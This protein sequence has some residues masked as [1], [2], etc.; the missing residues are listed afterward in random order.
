MLASNVVKWG[1]M[2]ETAPEDKQEPILSTSNL[3]TTNMTPQQWN[4]TKPLQLEQKSAICHSEK[5]SS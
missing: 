5:N 4:Q 1:I 3:K 2:H